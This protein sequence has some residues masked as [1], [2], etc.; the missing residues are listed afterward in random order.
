[1]D[2]F[3]DLPYNPP[4]QDDIDIYFHSQQYFSRKQREQK[5][6]SLKDEV[7]DYAVDWYEGTAGSD[8]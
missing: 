3:Y 5:I 7:Y 4:T 2:Y 6:N 1:M 8:A